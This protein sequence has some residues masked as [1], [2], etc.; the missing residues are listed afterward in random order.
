MNK[1]PLAV[2]A[3]EVDSWEAAVERD[4]FFLV[5]WRRKVQADYWENPTEENRI[6]RDRVW[7]M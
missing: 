3:A 4:A 7:D 2:L 1:K 5:V 6:E